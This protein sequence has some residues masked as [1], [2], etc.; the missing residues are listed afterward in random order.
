MDFNS[1]YKFQINNLCIFQ[2]L[3]LIFDSTEQILSKYIFT[4]GRTSLTDMYS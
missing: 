2:R 4:P 1:G 3:N